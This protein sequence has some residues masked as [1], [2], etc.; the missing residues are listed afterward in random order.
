[1]NAFAYP[2]GDPRPGDR[3]LGGDQQRVSEPVQ[4][5]LA[6]VD[7]KLNGSLVKSAP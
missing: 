1:M 6:L 7:H 3:V 2:T 4:P 5:R